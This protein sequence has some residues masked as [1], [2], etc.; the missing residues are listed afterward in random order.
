MFWIGG[1]LT[2]ENYPG[3]SPLTFEGWI[4]RGEPNKNGQTDQD[5]V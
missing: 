4:K 2:F 1:G 5:A 3:S